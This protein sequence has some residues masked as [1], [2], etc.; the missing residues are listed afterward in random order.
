MTDDEVLAYVKACAVALAL[1]LDEAR[2][3]RVAV[4]LARTAAMAA[5]LDAV[6]LAPHDELAEIYCPAPFVI[7]SDRMETL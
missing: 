7:F 3:A 2:A 4:N 6:P 1:P 5:L